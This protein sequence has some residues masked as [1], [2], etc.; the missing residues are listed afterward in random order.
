MEYGDA[1]VW[2]TAIALGA[3]ILVILGLILFL[4]F[5]AMQQPPS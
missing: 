2:L 4:I 3:S 1:I 5:K